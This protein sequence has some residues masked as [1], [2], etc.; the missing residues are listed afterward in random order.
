MEIHLK[1]KLSIDVIYFRRTLVVF[2]DLSPSRSF[3]NFAILVVRS[4]EHDHIYIG[5]HLNYDSQEILHRSK[6]IK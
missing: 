6:N 1:Q 3:R 2:I 5:V 4:V